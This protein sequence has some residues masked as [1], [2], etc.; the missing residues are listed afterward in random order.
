MRLVLYGG[1]FDPP[2]IAHLEI[3]KEVLQNLPLDLMI[4]MVAYH[5]PLKSQC[6]F[7][8][9]TR[10]EWMKR[11]CKEWDKVLVSDY[12]IANK[13]SYTLESIE[14]LEKKYQ[15]SSIDLI[16]GED[17]FLTLDKWHK[18]DLLKQKVNFVL[19]RRKGFEY[20]IGDFNIRTIEL[21]NIDIPISSTQIREGQGDRELDL[22]PPIILEDVLKK[23]RR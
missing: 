11:V 17:N 13:V 20:N 16:L 6:R 2:H 18:I 19:V 23:L 21:K 14:Y 4:I 12:E 10:L 22:I 9:Q 7:D 5:N 15:P 1:S 8:E 3:I